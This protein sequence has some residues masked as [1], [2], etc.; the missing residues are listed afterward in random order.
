MSKF[1]TEQTGKPYPIGTASFQN[2]DNSKIN[3]CCF[4][5]LFIVL[6][7]ENRGYS[8]YEQIKNGNDFAWHESG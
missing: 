4:Y 8:D 7:R 2:W 3:I 5:I 1:V 6:S